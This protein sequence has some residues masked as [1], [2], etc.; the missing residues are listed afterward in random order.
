MAK[1]K[2]KDQEFLI[3]KTIPG[4]I[5]SKAFCNNCLAKMEEKRK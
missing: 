1:Y 4:E 3:S 5:M 2:T